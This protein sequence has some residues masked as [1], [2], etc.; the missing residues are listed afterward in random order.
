MV[1]DNRFYDYL[2]QKITAPENLR[3]DHKIIKNFL[4]NL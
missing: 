3:K 1:S 4:Q 2:I